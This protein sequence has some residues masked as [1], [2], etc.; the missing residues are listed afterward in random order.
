MAHDQPLPEGTLLD[1]RY[2]L[3]ARIG[4]GGMATVYEAEDLRLSRVVALKVLKGCHASASTDA[5][6]MFRDA[7][8]AARSDHPS[9]ITV[10]GYG[11]DEEE[12]AHFVAMERLRGETLAERIARVGPLPLADVV[13]F[14]IALFDAL[15]AV[16]GAQVIHR[17]LK[18]ANIF[19]A[20][21]GRRTDE[22]TL[23]DFGVSRA[24]DLSTL[25]AT[26]ETYGTPAY[27]APE[28]LSDSRTVGPRTDLY[29]LGIVL[30]ECVTGRLP[31]KA[32]AL[33]TLTAE[34]LL[35]PNL[36]V[37]IYRPEC[38]QPLAEIIMRCAMREPAARFA[39]A[40]EVGD[41][42]AAL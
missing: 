4:E 33:A 18:P 24:L 1:G 7:R 3:R 5:E 13:R 23:L 41:A 6:R 32:K 15:D 28:L 25:T 20:T 30:Y 27:M 42:L 38:P 21:R 2:C 31:F 39:R 37:R 26:G 17:D 11:H 19:L 16:H 14:G 10:Y 34:I 29:A 8:N 12:D 40:A 36:D 35:G 9:V 22:V